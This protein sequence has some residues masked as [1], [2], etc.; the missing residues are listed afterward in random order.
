VCSC[1]YLALKEQEIKRQKKQK[2]YPFPQILG[3]RGSRE[4]NS[5]STCKLLEDKNTKKVIFVF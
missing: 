5:Y 1:C 4:L 2:Y 3:G